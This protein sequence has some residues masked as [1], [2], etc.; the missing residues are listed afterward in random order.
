VIAG[1]VRKREETLIADLDLGEATRRVASSTPSAT[2]TGPTSSAC[3][4][5]LHPARLSWKLPVAMGPARWPHNR[6]RP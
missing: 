2:T 3:S 5:I 1:L 4:S 6:R